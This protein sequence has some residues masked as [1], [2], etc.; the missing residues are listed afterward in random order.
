MNKSGKIILLDN[1][2][3][4]KILCD[5][6]KQLGHKNEIDCF[7]DAEAAGNY[8]RENLQDVFMLLQDNT[9]AA[10]QVPDT[11]NMVFMHEKFDTEEIPYMFMVLTK[12]KQPVERLHTF[13]HCYYKPDSNSNQLTDT[14][15]KVVNFWKDHVFPPRVTK[16]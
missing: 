4:T 15:G 12:T 6:L 1:S 5:S 3:N 8:L 10:V 16:L 7:D 11:R 9:S 2:G 13:I 14:L